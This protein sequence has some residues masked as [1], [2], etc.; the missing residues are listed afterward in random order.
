MKKNRKIIILSLVIV[1]I[2]SVVLLMVFKKKKEDFTGKVVV[3]NFI[4]YSNSG[5]TSLNDEN[6]LQFCDAD[7]GEK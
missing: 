1:V 2:I 7:S 3:S 4:S 5:T 6:L